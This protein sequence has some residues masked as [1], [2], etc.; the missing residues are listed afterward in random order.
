L[1]CDGPRGK[2]I[3]CSVSEGVTHIGNKAEDQRGGHRV[4]EGQTSEVEPLVNMDVA[5]GQRDWL[6]G[7]EY[8]GPAL[9]VDP[10]VADLFQP[11]Q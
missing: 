8:L 11:I 5:A 1:A 7:V 9:E 3:P 6:M 2:R 10:G 4:A